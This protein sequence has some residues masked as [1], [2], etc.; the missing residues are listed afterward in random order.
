MMDG[1]IQQI[2][3]L[4]FAGG[5]FAIEALCIQQNKVLV[6][7]SAAYKFDYV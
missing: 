5:C 2:D 6:L 3:K 4:S 1:P 7:D